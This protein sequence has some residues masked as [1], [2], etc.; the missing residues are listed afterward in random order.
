[1]IFLPENPTKPRNWF[2]RIRCFFGRHSMQQARGPR[3]LTG[4]YVFN[5][6]FVQEYEIEIP[7]ICKNCLRMEYRRG[8]ALTGV[9]K[10][11]T[12]GLSYDENGF[13]LDAQGK[14]L[15]PADKLNAT[16]W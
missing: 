14:R 16:G 6:A 2:F 9:M 1:M 13:P 3:N 4:Y 10:T 7:H 12:K 11:L 5:P 15:P 8:Y